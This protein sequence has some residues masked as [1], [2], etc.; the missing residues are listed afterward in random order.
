ML[1]SQSAISQ[2]IEKLYVNMPDILN[3]TL[4]KQNRLELVEYFKAK[5]GDS[6]TN[7]FGHQ[8]YLL[9]LDTVNQQIEVKNTPSSTFG[10][11]IFNLEV[12]KRAI[13]I[14]CTVCAPACQSTIEFYDTAWNA[15]PIKFDMPK[16]KEWVIEKNI[17]TES[18]DSNWVKSLMKISFISLRFSSENNL[19]QAKNNTLEFLSEIDRKVLT[20]FISDKTIAIELQGRTW[21]PKL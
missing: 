12:S 2:T 16:A 17:P 14:I 18:I 7:R 8:A 1:I 4:T 3:P 21:R 13:G 5:K 6:I 9:S 20:P 11:K 10:M 15:I 19:I